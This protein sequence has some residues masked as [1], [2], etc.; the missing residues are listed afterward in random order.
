MPRSVPAS[1]NTQACAAPPAPVDGAHPAA[2]RFA[3]RRTFP[4][5]GLTLEGRRGQY[6][7]WGFRLIEDARPNTVGY[8]RLHP[9]NAI[10]YTIALPDPAPS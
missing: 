5:Y 10:F 3:L 4:D 1:R 2:A 8:D 7:A 9:D 6:R